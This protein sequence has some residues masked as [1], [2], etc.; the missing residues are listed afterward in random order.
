M[1]LVR[2]V[3]KSMLC[4]ICLFIAMICISI[5]QINYN[6]DNKVYY[7]Y[8]QIISDY[9]NIN[10]DNVGITAERLIKAYEQYKEEDSKYIQE[11][12]ALVKEKEKYIESYNA[13]N[14]SKNY[15]RILQSTLFG[16]DDSFYIL[17]ASK[18]MKDKESC[19]SVDIGICN[20]TAIEK[21][22]TNRTMPLLY[23]IV[24]T[25]IIIYF[26]EESDNGVQVLVRTS[27]RGR[28]LLPIV[29]CG[30]III[31]NIVLSFLYNGVLYAIYTYVYGSSEGVY[32]QNSSMFN[33]FPYAISI[34]KF[35][36]IYCLVYA[37]AM[38]TIGLFIYFAIN[39]IS[40]YKVAVTLVIVI[41]LCEYLLYNKVSYNSQL[42]MFK[43]IN[44]MNILFAGT[45]Y[46]KYENWGRDGFITDISTTTFVITAVMLVVSL[47]GSIAVY[48]SKY[49]IRKKNII[50]I[51]LDKIHILIQ[52]LMYRMSLLLMEIYKTLVIQK[53]ILFILALVYVLVTFKIQRGVNYSNISYKVNEFY[54]E[55]DGYAPDEEVEAYI[56]NLQDELDITQ[57][58]DKVR[59]YQQ[60]MLAKEQRNIDAMRAAV[61]YVNEV[62][63][64]K[65]ASV[66]IVNPVNYDD[67]L[68]ERMFS[69][70]ESMNLISIIIVI[71]LFAGDYAFER[72]N[73]MT[74]HIRSAKGRVR[75]WNNKMLK[76]VIITT[77]LWL[78]STIINIHNIMGRYEYNQ[79]T[80]SIW[81]LQ[82]FKDC[83]VNISIRSYII[84]CSIYRLV[85]ML[86]IAF[87]AYIISYRFSYKVSLMVSFVMLIPHI[88]Y[89]LGVNWAQ[90]LSIVVGMDIN[91]M[92][93]MYGYNT[94]SIALLLVMSVIMCAMTYVTYRKNIK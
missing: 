40:N 60:E 2:I 30:I 67:I 32:I 68:G 38:L 26:T 8:R 93:R 85:W 50:D 12:A 54:K 19:P 56:T 14:K 77:L 25:I 9:D 39:L 72:Q 87:I 73:K 90:R 70:N 44:I 18:Q 71:L 61:D 3:R 83:P 91:R 88:I 4:I 51:M 15:N 92:F 6:Q 52:K 17:N 45:S 10:N 57:Q 82:M 86:V 23:I 89:I 55:F 1:E 33:M 66:V 53:G 16:G 43:Y 20:T 7:Y 81:C 46:L 76:V 41:F 5:Y 13:D 35:F 37:L 11:A 28:I 31:Y 79:L 22:V 24:F 59:L 42:N 29:R 65:A 74:A 80:Q 36:V 34:N 69:N 84:L 94:K 47:I 64:T 21:L 58:D 27:R 78:L 63:K 75:L 49:T 62:S 48:S